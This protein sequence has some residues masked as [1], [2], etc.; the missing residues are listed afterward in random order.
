MNPNAPFAQLRIGG[1]AFRPDR[2][3]V[4]LF[5]QICHAAAISLATQGYPGRDF[6]EIAAKN[7]IPESELAKVPGILSEFMQVANT[8]PIDS[9]QE[10][11]FACGMDKIPDIARIALFMHMGI[12]LMRL[13]HHHSRLANPSGY[14]PVNSEEAI[15]ALDKAAWVKSA[16]LPHVQE[17]RL[18]E[19]DKPVDKDGNQIV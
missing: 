4:N 13:Y 6:K 18:Q 16:D 10:A 5:P 15:E 9:F 14:Q 7:N 3:V 11:W 2:D 17:R 19:I 8:M 1:Q 12:A